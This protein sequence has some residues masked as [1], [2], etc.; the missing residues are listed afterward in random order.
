MATSGGRRLH[1][2][3]RVERL[4]E[5]LLPQNRHGD[6]RPGRL[7]LG[8]D[9]HGDHDRL[10][11]VEA[12]ERL[13]AGER[14]EGP[15]DRSGQRL[16]LEGLGEK[17]R[18]VDDRRGTAN[19]DPGADRLGGSGRGGI[20]ADPVAVLLGELLERDLRLL[21]TF[22]AEVDLPLLELEKHCL[23]RELP[24]DVAP[25]ARLTLRQGRQAGE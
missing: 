17:D 3:D 19:H 25:G 22:Q 5:A 9:V 10:G 1:R 7:P 12:V 13:A 24:G 15:G 4:L 8:I 11:D 20:G 14:H 23:P 2:K 18:V 16:L 6:E 21:A